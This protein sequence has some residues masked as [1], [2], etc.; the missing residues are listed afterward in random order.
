VLL[1]IQLSVLI[2]KLVTYRCNFWKWEFGST[3]Y[4]FNLYITCV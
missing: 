2:I 3:V 1:F 4:N